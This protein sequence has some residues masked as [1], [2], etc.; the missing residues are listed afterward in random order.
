MPDDGIVALDNGM[1]KIWFARGYRTHLANTILLDNALA[2]MGAGLPS[3][4]MAALLY[5]TAQSGGGVRRR[6]LHDEL[7]RARDR[8]ALALE[9][10]RVDHRGRRLRDDPLEASRGR[11]S[12]TSGLSFG[13]P[14]FVQVRRGV[15]RARRARASDRELEPASEEAFARGGVHVVMVPIDYTENKRVLVDELRASKKAQRALRVS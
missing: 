15:R 2:T 14:D 13:N 11:T 1:Y 7:A 10:G 6:R 12:R 3:A 5:P 4:M 9:S 8:G